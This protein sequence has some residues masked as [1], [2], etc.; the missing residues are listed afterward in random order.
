MRPFKKKTGHFRRLQKF[1]QARN[2]RFH[3][4]NNARLA[5]DKSC[6]HH[7]IMANSWK[8]LLNWHPELGLAPELDPKLDLKLDLELNKK[9]K[10]MVN[11]S[12]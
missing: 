4:P 10:A 3:R 11:L 1:T 5:L 9:G 2:N 8:A 6:N 7:V 12:G